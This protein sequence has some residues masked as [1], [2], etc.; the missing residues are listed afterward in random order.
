M[1]IKGTEKALR[2][3]YNLKE[4]VKALIVTKLYNNSP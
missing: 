4:P 3:A 1:E 2:I